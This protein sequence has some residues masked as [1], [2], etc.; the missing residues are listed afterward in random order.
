MKA[1][2]VADG[3]MDQFKLKARLDAGNT[4][5]T[6]LQSMKTLNEMASVS[7]TE[8]ML[9]RAIGSTIEKQK[10]RTQVLAL[11]AFLRGQTGGDG[12]IERPRKGFGTAFNQAKNGEYPGTK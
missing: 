9:F 5:L 10:L 12:I 2:T 8:F 6:E 11:D 7:Y 4:C 1:I 3:I